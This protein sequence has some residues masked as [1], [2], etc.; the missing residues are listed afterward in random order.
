MKK[1]IKIQS[2]KVVKKEV[3]IINEL[4]LHARPAAMFVKLANEFSADIMVEKGSE[5]VNGKSIM[6]IMMLAAGKGSKITLIAQ[7]ADAQ[8]A[9]EEIEKLVKSKFGEE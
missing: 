9:V 5:Q 2:P 8:Q 7:G 1:D 4:G 6:G 3:E